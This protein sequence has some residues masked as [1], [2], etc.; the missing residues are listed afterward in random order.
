MRGPYSGYRRLDFELKLVSARDPIT[1][2]TRVTSDY[3]YL[4]LNQRRKN[5]AVVQLLKEVPGAQDIEL[6]L[7]MN[8]YSSEFGTQTT[9][10]FFGTAV[11]KIHIFVT[12]ADW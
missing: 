5:E 1:G 2:E 10:V 11:A 4:K 6:Q 3:F 7:N 9:E 12:K 8:I